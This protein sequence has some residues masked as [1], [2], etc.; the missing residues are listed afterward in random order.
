MTNLGA[1]RQSAGMDPSNRRYV[2]DLIQRM[3]KD[4]LIVITTHSM[5]E[6]EALADKVAIVKE[7]TLA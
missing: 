1:Q 7:G 5:E 2:W 4:R 3:K 6:A